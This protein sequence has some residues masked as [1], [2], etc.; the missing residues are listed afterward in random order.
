MSGTR[1]GDATAGGNDL[2]RAG[3][4]AGATRLVALDLA[5]PAGRLEALLAE[6]EG[7]RSDVAALVC[8]PHP[9]Y[10][11]TMHNKVVHRVAATLHALGADVLRFNFRGAGKSEGRHDHG[12][13]ELE[14]ARVALGHL[15]TLGASRLWLAGFSFGSWIAARLAAEE[16]GLERLILIAPPVRRSDFDVLARVAVPKLVVQGT[17]DTVCPIEELERVWSTW[18]EPKTLVRVDGATH[19]FDR[20]LK[21]LDQ[22]L[23]ESLAGSGKGGTSSDARSDS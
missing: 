21:A 17:A 4:E 19:F 22:A 20:Q 16:Q 2:A 14:D 10:G 18:A 23:V 13:G 12:R 5:G 1:P 3:D 8:H 6:R 11:G 15:R 7:G 9:S